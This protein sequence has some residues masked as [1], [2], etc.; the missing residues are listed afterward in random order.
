VIGDALFHTRLGSA[1]LLRVDAHMMSGAFWIGV[2]K[3]FKQ[4]MWP[5]GFSGKLG[6][7]LGAFSILRLIEVGFT[8]GFGSL[9][10]LLLGY[11][12]KLLG[13]LV[14]PVEPFIKARLAQL[15]QYIGWPEAV[16]AH[17]RHVFV[18]LGLY[19]FRE[20]GLS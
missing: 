1:T 13:W 15:H 3:F 19:F 11:Y 14:W 6:R 8:S 7:I 2:G 18:L 5:T 16:Y 4:S 10:G 20:V 17:W 12:E 9:L